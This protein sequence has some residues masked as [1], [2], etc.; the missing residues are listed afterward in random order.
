MEFT[1]IKDKVLLEPLPTEETVDGG[2]IILPKASQKI[3]IWAKVLACGEDVPRDSVT[4]G[5]KVF[6]EGHLGTRVVMAGMSYI[7]VEWSKI[8]MKKA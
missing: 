1:P 5:D 6:L 3:N 4:D 2:K 8:K 7:I